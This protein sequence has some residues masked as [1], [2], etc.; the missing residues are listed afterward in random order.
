LVAIGAGFI[1]LEIAATAVGAG[2]DVTV[3]EAAPGALGRMVAPEVAAALVR[4]HE[5]R[6][7]RFHFNAAVTRI[8]DDGGRPVVELASGERI[9]ADV[10]VVGIGGLPN[11]DLAR[12]SGLN[13]EGGICV[14]EWGATSDAAIY[15]VGDVCRQHSPAL[16]RSI[17]LESWQNA[18]NGGIAIGK[19]IAGQREPWSD[20]PWFWTDQYEDNFQIVGAPE[21]WDRLIW[22]G[23]QEDDKFTVLYLNEG[24]VV[25]GNALNTAR[26]IRPIK[27]MII[28]RNVI[29]PAT[30]ADTSVPLVKIQKLQAAQ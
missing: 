17:R 9:P 2:A 11:D 7:V 29:D 27:Q 5:R 20:I 24:R 6:G 26:D 21:R 18:Q 28:D 4:R 25:A 12:A 19:A 14:D 8:T 30:L 16:G 3:L 13:C 15:A 23:S 22:R 1:G 10:V